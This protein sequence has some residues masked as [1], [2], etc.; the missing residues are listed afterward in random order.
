MNWKHK[1]LY[2]F[3]G[4]TRIDVHKI[5]QLAQPGEPHREEIKNM[6]PGVR[7]TAFKSWI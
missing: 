1:I 2:S 7:F 4:V 3:C 5:M 6:E